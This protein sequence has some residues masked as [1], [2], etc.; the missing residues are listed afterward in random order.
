MIS[1]YRKKELDSNSRAK[2]FSQLS[3]G[4]RTKMPVLDSVAI[5]ASLATPSQSSRFE[6]FKES[7]TSGK[8]LS[9]AGLVSG[10][11]L[12]WEARLVHA[13]QISG[14]LAE[15]YA[16]LSVRHLDQALRMGRL[17]SM[18]LMPFALFVLMIVLGPLRSLIDGQISSQYYLI[19]T[20]GRLS[21]FFGG[22][23]VLTYNWKQLSA[24]GADNSIF[25][26]LLHI[27]K[28]GNLIRQQQRRDFLYC[29]TLLLEAGVPAFKGLEIAA[30]SVSH[31]D[32]RRKFLESVQYAK[33]GS[34]LSTAIESCGAVTG[35]GVELLRT[36]EF[37][38]RLTEI[39][40]HHVVHLGTQ[41]DGSYQLLADWTPRVIYLIFLGVFLLRF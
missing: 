24:S 3:L 2:L 23:Y 7:I 9:E 16:A 34:T 30:N 22:I 10:L 39:L 36:A 5:A 21:L 38:G 31:P 19:L 33:S 37:S 26:L 20:V 25:R 18:Q 1:R 40:R 14:K 8:D 17:K 29:L 28:L 41:L 35:A 32:L 6:Q 15:S 12:P 13:A 4:E 27:P 11:F